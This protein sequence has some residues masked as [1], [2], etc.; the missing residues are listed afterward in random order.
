MAQKAAIDVV[1]GHLAVADAPAIDAR[2]S[3]LV[4]VGVGDDARDV[5]VATVNLRVNVVHEISSSPDGG[6]R[7]DDGPGG[8]E[9]H[10]GWACVLGIA[11]FAA[12]E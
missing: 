4:H 9:V 2:G 10:A 11:A 5:A 8:F 1:E 6:F 7:P 3:L 12:N